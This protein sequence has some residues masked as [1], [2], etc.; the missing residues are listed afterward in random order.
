MGNKAYESYEMLAKL[1]NSERK[2]NIDRAYDALS[3]ALAESYGET[4]RKN[5]DEYGKKR[6]ALA[7]N[8]AKA[9]KYLDYFMT[10]KGYSGSGIEADAKLKAQL[11]YDSDLASLYASEN[12]AAAKAAAEHEAALLKNEA[13]RAEAHAGADKDYAELS[14]KAANDAASDE[15]K[16]QQIETERQSEL[17]QNRLKEEAQKADAE[18]KRKSL[19]SQNSLKEKEYEIKLLQAQTDAAKA[20][21]STGTQK[22]EAEELQEKLDSYRQLMYEELKNSFSATDDISE[23]QRIYDSVTGVNTEKATEIYGEK[24]Y[25][26][27]IRSLSKGLTEAKAAQKDAQVVQMLYDRFA[28]AKDEYHYD[29][30]LKLKRALTS[31]GYPGYTQ[32][33]LDR[34]YKAYKNNN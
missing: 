20:S 6:S 12:E 33:Q 28:E 25:K 21:A 14:Y 1:L 13:Q 16:R 18:Y 2:E 34:A 32:D 3:A 9:E 30:Y 29:T 26:E 15:L 23:K 11:A 4:V 22:K 10:E 8:K 24:L 27:L 5:A 7:A 19:E 31:G 17:E